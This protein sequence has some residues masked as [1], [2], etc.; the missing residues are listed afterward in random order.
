M[1]VDRSN[2]FDVIADLP[3]QV[4]DSIK[5]CSPITLQYESSQIRNIVF[6]GIGGSS[7][8]G[9]LLKEYLYNDLK[10]PFIPIR[11]YD[12]PSF[13]D[14]DTLLF[15]SSYSGN[16]QETLSAY[17]KAKQKEAKIIVLTSGG[18]LKNF[19][20][21]DNIPIIPIP[22]SAYFIMIKFR[23]IVIESR[24]FTVF[25]KLALPSIANRPHELFL[26]I[27]NRDTAHQFICKFQ[28]LIIPG[29]VCGRKTL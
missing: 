1:S 27:N 13:I 8:G 3:N 12:I 6:C 16:T 11:N 19:A 22:P 9:M 10:I 15:V 4:E 23:K 28:C 25:V 26:A 21:R 20:E 29:V 24:P 17:E 18:K 14:K 2:M 7:I 5:I